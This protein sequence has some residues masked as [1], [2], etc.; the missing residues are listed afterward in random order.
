MMN[1]TS[2]IILLYNTAELTVLKSIP[3]GRAEVEDRERGKP[4]DQVFMTRKMMQMNDTTTC[5]D[6]KVE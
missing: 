3:K 6:A 2:L 4:K 1:R 5:I